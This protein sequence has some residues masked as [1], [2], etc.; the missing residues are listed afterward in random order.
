VLKN[1][2]F[3]ICGDMQRN[4]SINGS[5]YLKFLVVK[6]GNQPDSV[7]VQFLVKMSSEFIVRKLAGIFYTY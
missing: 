5:L 6:H 4:L 2:I 7:R 1:G 3:Y